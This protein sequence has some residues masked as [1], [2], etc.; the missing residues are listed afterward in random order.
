MWMIFEKILGNTEKL[1]KEVKT[2]GFWITVVIVTIAGTA[3]AYGQIHAESL[4]QIPFAIIIMATLPGIAALGFSVDFAVM[5]IKFHRFFQRKI[6]KNHVTYYTK[7]QFSVEPRTRNLI[8]TNVLYSFGLIF[9]ILRSVGIERITNGNIMVLIIGSFFLSLIFA[10]GLNI[11]IYLMRK[12]G[13]MFENT[14]DGSRINLG[15]QFNDRIIIFVAPLQIASFLYV[16]FTEIDLLGFFISLGISLGFCLGSS[17][18]SF[19]FLKKIHAEKLMTK[20]TQRLLKN[21]LVTFET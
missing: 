15:S 2:K 11:A 10:S 7:K 16:I 1:R 21:N 6:R 13:I 14:K 9:F 18:F 8:L 3:Y 4:Y 19:Y 20:F 5:F 17:A 12:Q